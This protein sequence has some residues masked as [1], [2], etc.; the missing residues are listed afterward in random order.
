MNRNYFAAEARYD[1]KGMVCLYSFQGMVLRFGN[2]K[3]DKGIIHHDS[4]SFFKWICLW[5]ICFRKSGDDRGEENGHESQV[6]RRHWGSKM[7]EEQKK[8]KD[9]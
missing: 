4:G 6:D 7:K 9:Y 5:D 1:C 3:L 2:E 8:M